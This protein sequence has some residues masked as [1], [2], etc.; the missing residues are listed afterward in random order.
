MDP[1]TVVCPLCRT[2]NVQKAGQVMD[3]AIYACDSCNAQFTVKIPRPT[4]RPGE[5]KW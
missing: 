1:P 2:E 3:L 5:A 4:D